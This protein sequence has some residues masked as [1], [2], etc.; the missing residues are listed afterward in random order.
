LPDLQAAV[1]ASRRAVL[2]RPKDAYIRN[3]LGAVLYRAG[4]D[5]EAVKELNESIRLN[6]AGGSPVDFLFLAMACQRLGKPADAQSWLARA[7]QAHGKQALAV[8]WVERLEWEILDRE[9]KLLPSSTPVP[10]E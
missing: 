7:A 6:E 5:A 8:F 3:T 4:Q 9:A 1:E 10:K 2:A